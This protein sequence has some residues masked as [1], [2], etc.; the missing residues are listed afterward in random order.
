MFE[1]I[2]TAP[3][4]Q[5]TYPDSGDRDAQQITDFSLDPV[6]SPSGISEITASPTTTQRAERREGVFPLPRAG[7]GGAVFQQPP[8]QEQVREQ[9]ETALKSRQVS[10]GGQPLS[11]GQEFRYTRRQTTYSKSK[12]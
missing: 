4:F 8:L 2:A 11:L 5:Q 3:Y 9:E 6:L 7:S 10:G 12:S 1:R